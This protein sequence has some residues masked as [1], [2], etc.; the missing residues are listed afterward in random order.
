M[1]RCRRVHDAGRAY[2]RVARLAILLACAMLVP[3]G[4]AADTPAPATAAPAPAAAPAANA[5]TPTAGP[6]SDEY[7]G[8]PPPPATLRVL[9]RPVFEFRA[10]Y[11]GHPPSVRVQDAT[12]R[13][14]DIL[15]RGGPGAVGIR[16][17]GHNRV[18]TIDGQLAF[19]VLPGDVPG[20]SGEAMD[21]IANNVRIALEQAIAETQE[22]RDGRMMAR[23][24][25]AAAIATAIYA[26]LVWLLL[27]F[28]RWLTLRMLKVA[29]RASKRY[30]IGG[31][32]LMRGHRAMRITRAVLRVAGYDTVKQ[33]GKARQH[34]GLVSE[35]MIMYDELT[36]RENLKL[37]GK[38]YNLP[39]DVIN[40]R[41]NELLRFVRMEKWIFDSPDQ[42]G[43]AFRQFAKDFYDA[44]GAA[45]PGVSHK[46]RHRGRLRTEMGGFVSASLEF[47]A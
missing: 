11:F 28:G 45:V 32:E 21:A 20:G 12:A 5:T 27:R 4:A 23:G 2:R 37:F 19:A 33:S 8:P 7:A 42:A 30:R 26:A 22:A 18:L 43:E 24:A 46:P 39:N 9:N 40:T 10:P 13:I 29:G 25:I 38:L 15:E 1:S 34:I 3:P 44:P 47:L 14:Q 17:S 36:A 31:D 6:P 16:V 35:K 41:I